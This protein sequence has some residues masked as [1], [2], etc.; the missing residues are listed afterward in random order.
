MDKLARALEQAAT[1]TL[2]RAFADTAIHAAGE[3]DNV[4]VRLAANLEKA[5]RRTLVVTRARDISMC[6]PID[7]TGHLRV[8]SFGAGETT[9]RDLAEYLFPSN[10]TITL[11]QASVALALAHQCLGLGDS[12][13]PTHRVPMNRLKDTI[14]VVLAGKHIGQSLADILNII[15]D[16][17][18]YLWRTSSAKKRKSLGTCED[19]RRAL[20][21]R[22]FPL[23]ASSWATSASLLERI[24]EQ[25]PHLT[26]L[27]CPQ[28]QATPAGPAQPPPQPLLSDAHVL[29]PYISAA[30]CVCEEEG[31][32]PDVL[33]DVP[34]PMDAS[35]CWLETAQRTDHL[36][37]S[38]KKWI[39]LVAEAVGKFEE[40][41]KAF[42]SHQ[43]RL[44]MRM[45]HGQ[46]PDAK[47][48]R[49]EARFN[50]QLARLGKMLRK[51]SGQGLGVN[52]C[53]DLDTTTQS[54]PAWLAEP[55]LAAVLASNPFRV[56]VT[57][58]EDE[59]K[60]ACTNL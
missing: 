47:K 12:A 48:R 2:G 5:G 40:R 15:S 27:T 23:T 14:R 36:H 50:E 37:P 4:L 25:Y 33:V 24:S 39:T 34:P 31:E 1:S 43:Q 8:Y 32:C 51:A 6:L 7:A 42:L 11:P 10:A 3:A 54:L 59:V 38:L 57:F 60:N 46:E 52:V 45:Y 41:K 13:L 17:H 53:L 21:P 58:D 29:L 18:G 35:L 44:S 49:A 20:L 22:L 19:L 28:P 9:T 16:A 55:P 30:F 26:A 56:L